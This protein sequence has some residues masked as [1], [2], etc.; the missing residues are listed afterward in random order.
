MG[1]GVRQHSAGRWNRLE[2]DAEAGILVKAPRA[3]FRSPPSS[4]LCCC[5]G[6]RGFLIQE[7]V[8]RGPG[9]SPEEAVCSSLCGVGVGWAT[10]G[11]PP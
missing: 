9:A 1:V 8:C 4:R 5:P 11:T 3:S 6:S 2:G 10:S 7:A